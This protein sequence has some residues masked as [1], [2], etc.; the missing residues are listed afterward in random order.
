MQMEGFGDFGMCFRGFRG[1][2][3]VSPLLPLNVQ[4]CQHEAA[5][6]RPTERTEKVK[7]SMFLPYIGIVDDR[8]TLQKS[9]KKCN[10]NWKFIR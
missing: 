1:H 5:V 4:N 3:S 6:W 2:N 10:S 7:A 9:A 8:L